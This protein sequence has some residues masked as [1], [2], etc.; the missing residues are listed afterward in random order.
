MQALKVQGI[1]RNDLPYKAPF[2]PFGSW[3]ALI[4]TGVITIFKGFD[5]F[6][7]FELDTFATSYVGIP[8]FIGFYLFW[9]LYHRTKLIPLEQVDLFSGKREV[10]LEEEKYLAQQAALGPPT[11]WRKIW[12][13][14]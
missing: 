10:E 2:Q 12:D 4:N 1:S 5:T 9:K 13:S 7:P 3:F 14:L 11:R 6:M 8:A